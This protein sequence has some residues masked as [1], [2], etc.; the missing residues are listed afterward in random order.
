ML[1]PIDL[2]VTYVDD[3]DPV[4]R[5]DVSQYKVE[6]SP[7]RYRSRDIFKYWFRGIEKHMPFIRT[8]HLVVSN[9]EQ[10]P[11]WLDQSKVHVVLHKGIIPEDLLPTFNSTTIEMYL[12]KINGLA[13]HF[14]YSNDD[15]MPMNDMVV[16]DFFTE[17]GLPIYELVHRDE[18]RR[19]FRLQCKN[20]YRF[21]ARLTGY[22]DDGIH[23]F[24]IKHSVSPMLKS[25]CE[26]VHENAGDEIHKRCNK[27]RQPWNF[28]QYLFTD[29]TLMS[30]RAVLEKMSLCYVKM[31]NGNIGNVI[32]NNNEKIVCINDANVVDCFLCGILVGSGVG[33]LF[34][35]VNY[36]LFLLVQ[37]HEFIIPMPRKG[38]HLQWL[39]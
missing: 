31:S 7:Q 3:R 9:I 34:N 24:Y 36:G 4:W 27:F 21:A 10:V 20:S 37:F 39:P 28:T 23:Y 15:M 5:H 17:N 33:Q 26:E 11:E 19:S 29:Y 22:Q 35:Q 16:G 8:V 38:N 2:V 30:K 12:C 32:V 1:F 14:I 18:A 25:C 13:E 6:L